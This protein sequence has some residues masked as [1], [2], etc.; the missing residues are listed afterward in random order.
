MTTLRDPAVLL[1]AWEAGDGWPEVARG[2]L[3]LDLLGGAEDGGSALDLPIGELDRLAARCHVEAFGGLVLGVL[4]CTGCGA[5]LDVTVDLTAL[6]AATTPDGPAAGDE[7]PAVRAPTVRDLL[8]V[9]DRPDARDVLLQLLSGMTVGDLEPDELARVDMRLEA[10]AGPGFTTLRA[11]CPDCGDDVI[12][13]LDP[14]W[15]LWARVE[16]A[17]PELLRDVAQLAGA[18]GWSESEVLALTPQRRAAYLGLAAG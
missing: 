14:A 3:V 15:L 6:P 10:I 12:G 13:D 7:V 5:M 4:D 11:A 2:A 17:A 8:R 16:T 9:V 1:A 18:F